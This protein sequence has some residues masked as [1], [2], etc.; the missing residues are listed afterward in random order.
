M[1]STSVIR[2][3]HHKCSVLYLGQ[4]ILQEVLPCLRGLSQLPVCGGGGFCSVG[5]GGNWGCGGICGC[6]DMVF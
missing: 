2:M 4:E 1:Q 5:D 6:G 3:S